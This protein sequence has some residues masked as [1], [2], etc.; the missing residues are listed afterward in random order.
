MKSTRAKR[1]KIWKLTK[2]EIQ[3]ALD[4]LNS[5]TEILEKFN[6]NPYSGMRNTFMSRI[7]KEG[8]DLSKF[9]KNSNEYR[10]SICIGK[11][12]KDNKKD[13]SS[14][15][16]EN[17]SYSRGH[18]KKR[19]VSENILENKCS[20][21][22]IYDVWN[23]KPISLQLD[24]INGIRNDNRIK[25][26]RLLCPNCH[27]QTHTFSGRNLPLINKC[28]DCNCRIK[29]QNDRCR[30]CSS[31]RNGVKSRK[32]EI[33]K[34]ELII[35]IKQYPMTKVGEILGVSDNAI[36]KRC[37]RLEIDYKNL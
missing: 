13:L 27:S 19:L 10:K 1:S 25:N 21:C 6:L 36:R 5:Y 2:E 9:E 31:E 33:S 23:N 26:L 29:K 34:E 4:S 22:S 20:E 24:H 14:I 15:L 30:K 7:K 3:N 28:L 18:L 16:T 17:S 11:F 8:Y 32:F 12:S 37:K 35:L